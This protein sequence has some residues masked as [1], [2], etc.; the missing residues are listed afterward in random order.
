MEKKGGRT[1]KKGDQTRSRVLTSLI[2]LSGA[3]TFGLV[4]DAREANRVLDGIDIISQG[5][6][7]GS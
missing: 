3:R 1:G 6:S 2:R 5:Y 7:T 4:S